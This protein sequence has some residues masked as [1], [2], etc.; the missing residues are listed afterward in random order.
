[1]FW[2][3]VLAAI[4]ILFS[5]AAYSQAGSPAAEESPWSGSVSLGFLSTSGNTNTTSYNTSFGILYTKNKWTHAFDA[6]A[7]GAD[8]SDK[9]TAEAYQADWKTSYDIREHNYLFGLIGWRKDRFSGVNQQLTESVG[10]G[11]RIIDTPA[12]F[13]SVEIG[14]GHR[15][16]DLSDNTS[17]SSV[18][19]RLGL[20]YKWTFSETSN[21]EQT[22]SVEAG[23]DNTYTES[24][25]AVRAKLLG[26]LAIVLSYKVRHNTDVPVG[27][28]KTDKFTAISLE[29]AF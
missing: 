20:D 10:Y 4:L 3:A 24:V 15:S 25:S 19:G 11:R 21:F 7:N 13:L 27:D 22:I 12:H 9:V 29:L 17:E 5:G 26:D 6:A 1:M 2:N 8:E 14:A 28:E 18:I 23:P 16:A